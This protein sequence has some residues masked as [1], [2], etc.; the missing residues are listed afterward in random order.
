MKRFFIK[1]TIQLIFLIC[2]LH[3]SAFA[4]SPI[5]INGL[6]TDDITKEPIAYAHLAICGYSV[7]LIS[8]EYGE[9][10]FKIP[11]EYI[12]EDICISFVGYEIYRIP[13]KN[14]V[15][16]Q[17]LNIRL[18]R[19]IYTIDE[20]IIV[21]K[22]KKIPAKKIIERA[23]KNI[24]LNYPQ[25]SFCLH[26]YYRE[27]LK[28]EEKK[29]LNLFESAIS[30]AEKSFYKPS[31]RFNGWIY[32]QRYNSNFNVSNSFQ[33]VY[34]NISEDHKLIDKKAGVK[35]VPNFVMPV[36]GG[37]EL[38]I[39]FSHDPIRRYNE[40]TFSYVDYFNKDFIKNHHFNLDSVAF[41]GDI[42]LYCISFSYK[43][44]YSYKRGAT[45]NVNSTGD[46]VQNYDLHG[47]IR[48]RCNSYK[49][50]HFTYT[51]F[52][53]KEIGKK[54]Y[55]IVVDYKEYNNKMYL[56]YL[57]F[58]NFFKIT[59]PPEDAYL[60]LSEKKAPPK[61]KNVFFE[62]G[63][64]ILRFDKDLNAFSAR[65]NKKYIFSG[66]IKLLDNECNNKQKFVNLIEKPKF[67]Y[68][69]NKREVEISF[70]YAH[71]LKDMDSLR[72]IDNKIY[73]GTF[74]LTIENLTDRDGNKF[75]ESTALPFHQF[76][77]FYVNKVDSISQPQYSQNIRLNLTRPLYHQNIEKIDEFWDY[78]NYPSTKSF[79]EKGFNL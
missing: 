79:K 10:S 71:T 44:N 62:D 54:I 23:I 19:K 16:S 57:S 18:K 14:L 68:V 70:P 66:K 36:I 74:T 12:N 43:N 50:E 20:V 15:D 49:I 9:F 27:Y 8:N 35:F 4:N 33:T 69:I 47:N 38:A 29:Y 52:S 1:L 2:I 64:I 11:Y 7:G 40:K 6:I 25:K 30:I 76:R 55:E 3:S 77:E 34:S 67:V 24:P 78:F 56:N 26:G 65:R 53:T 17:F 63:R 41:K 31:L 59:I 5:I 73:F 13:V 28:Y 46:F 37:N 72:I 60:F 32:Q 21:A 39:L 51:N 61:L 42:P 75:G 48:I 45:S 22:S 58:S